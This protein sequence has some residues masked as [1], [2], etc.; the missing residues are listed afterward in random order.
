MLGGAFAASQLRIHVRSFVLDE[1]RTLLK[2]HPQ[3]CAIGADPGQSTRE[4]RDFQNALWADQWSYTKGSPFYQRRLG[5]LASRE[6][7]LDAIGELP[8]TE[9]DDLRKSQEGAY[10]FGDYVRCDHDR[11]VRLHK[12][13]GTTGR[14]LHLA[15][16]KRDVDLIVRVG[17]RSFYA[18]GLRPGDRV[19][20][21]LN[22]CMWTGGLTDHL[23]LEAAGACVVPYGTGGTAKLLE[24]IEDIGINAISCTPSYPALLEKILHETSG[25]K[26]RDL[27]LRLGLFGGEAGLDNPEF[28]SAMEGTW[29]FSVRN[30]NYGTSE[31]LSIFGG[32]CERTNDLHFHGSDAI[33]LEVSGISAYGTELRV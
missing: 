27:G 12:T 4:V 24:T 18:A 25:K 23:A 7:S 17:G 29:G 1:N 16:S 19:V 15:N 8:F 20:H 31:V 3:F 26:P 32:Q 21:C 11:I 5:S 28:R 22:Y 6:I 2:S 14:P 33:F 13:S 10:P 30:A 9:K